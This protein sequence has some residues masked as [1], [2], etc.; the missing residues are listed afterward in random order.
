MGLASRVVRCGAGS[1]KSG[2]VHVCKGRLTLSPVLPSF[3]PP[4]SRRSNQK[5]IQA[6]VERRTGKVQLTLVWNAPS[7]KEAGGELSRLL[8]ALKAAD[9]GNVRMC[10]VLRMRR[11]GDG[12]CL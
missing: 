10:V 12:G 1:V 8:K 11:G 3:R 4:F 2:C 7:R 6:A 5:F 9:P